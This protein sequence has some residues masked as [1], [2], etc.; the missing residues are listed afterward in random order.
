MLSVK[1]VSALAHAVDDADEFRWGI[2]HPFG[3]VNAVGSGSRALYWLK[4]IE[5]PQRPLKLSA[6][7]GTSLSTK[8]K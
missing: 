4:Y 6:Q 1:A 8:E 2:G 7:K 5:L 3:I